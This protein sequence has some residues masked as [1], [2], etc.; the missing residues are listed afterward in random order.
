MH[1][2]GINVFISFVSSLNFWM[3]RDIYVNMH[4]MALL[5][6]SG[7]S[8]YFFFI[9]ASFPCHSHICL[10]QRGITAL[11]YPT[12]LWNNKYCDK[13]YKN[14]A[15]L[16]DSWKTNRSHATRAAKQALLRNVFVVFDSWFL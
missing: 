10:A 3:V 11:F 8:Q 16:S 13:S 15:D 2:Y 4:Y 14:K 12:P 9:P 5:A 1:A 6:E 7:F